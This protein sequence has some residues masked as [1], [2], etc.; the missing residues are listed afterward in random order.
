MQSP[1]CNANYCPSVYL[2]NQ[3]CWFHLARN[4]NSNVPRDYLIICPSKWSMPWLLRRRLRTNL[5]GRRIYCYKRIKSTQKLA[6]SLAERNSTSRFEGTI[7]IAERQGNATGRAG[8]R[9]ISPAG[10]IWLSVILNPNLLSSQSMLIMFFNF[11][12][13]DSK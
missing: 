2:N 3:S 7:V 12:S 6:V 1:V 4:L 10:G 5:I 13:R 9:W 11:L 8:R